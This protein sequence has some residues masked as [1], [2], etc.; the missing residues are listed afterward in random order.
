[1]IKINGETREFTKAVTIN[2]LIKN[3]GYVPAHVAV[4]RNEAI[5]PRASFSEVYTADGDE[6]EIVLFVAG[7]GRMPA[8]KPRDA[9]L[10]KRKSR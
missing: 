5:V 1:M 9:L 8:D 4:E 6:I 10:R 2:E 7:G 3:E